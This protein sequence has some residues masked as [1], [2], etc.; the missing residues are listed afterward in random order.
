[1]TTSRSRTTA[2]LTALSFCGAIGQARAQ[3]PSQFSYLPPGELASGV[4]RLNDRTIYFPGIMFPLRAGPNFENAQAYAGSQVFP[5][6]PGANSEKNYAYPWRDTYCEKR[7]WDMPL[8]PGKIGHQGVDIRPEKPQLATFPAFAIDDGIITS[9]TRFTTVIVRFKQADGTAYSC[10]YMHMDFNSIT[11]TGLKVG[12]AVRRGTVLGKVANIM[13]GSASTSIHLHFDC[14]KVINGHTVHLPVYTSLISSYRVAWGLSDANAQGQLEVDTAH[15]VGAGGEN[16]GPGTG[17]GP[18]TLP[19]SFRTRNYGAITP[20]TEPKFWPDYLKQWPNLLSNAE[21]RDA[22][23]KVIP[24]FST[25]EAGIGVWWYWMVV[26]AGFGASGSV[27]FEQIA[28][29]YSG[30]MEATD[31]SVANYLTGYLG[32]A[33]TYFGRPVDKAEHF[34][35]ANRDMRWKLAQTIFQFEGGRAVSFAQGVFDNGVALGANIVA[36]GFGH[37]APTGPGPTPGGGTGPNGTGPSVC[38][39]APGAPLS[40]AIEISTGRYTMRF[41]ADATQDSIVKVLDILDKRK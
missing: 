40:G 22:F 11:A 6:F 9:I 15:E 13:G 8:C 23:G 34:D 2:L 29:K 18:D 16:T 24:A 1:M 4:G 14:Q 19:K 33:P 38:T 39:A 41:G 35:L 10:R 3:A 5:A 32:F 26:R 20:Q 27:S 36:N 37:T 31:P 30:A 12:D 21:V 25:D 7:S 28:T 17:L